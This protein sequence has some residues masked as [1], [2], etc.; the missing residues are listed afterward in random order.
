MKGSCGL[1]LLLALP[2]ATTPALEVNPSERYRLRVEY[3]QWRPA[4]T[5]TIQKGS[6]G[7]AGTSIDT[8]ADLGLL[9]K[10]T[11]EI[12]GA[13]QVAPGHKLRGSYTPVEYRGDLSVPRAFR[14]GGTTYTRSERVVTSLKGGY[15]TGE[16]QFDVVRSK[17][18]YLGGIVGAKVFDLASVLV[19]PDS[20]HRESDT[21]RIPIPV[22]GAAGRLYLGTLSLCGEAS[23]LTIGKRG[24]LYELHGSAAWHVSDRLAVQ[25]GYRMLSLRGEDAPDAIDLRLGGWM[26]GGQVSF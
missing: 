12:R 1:L 6:G 4:L 15:Y 26:L 24:H 9:D 22:L 23:G 25:G 21:E 10:K 2:P 18:G 19:A 20:A 7:E 16:Y 14:F 3:W 8:K 17:G 11:F 5:S 13:W